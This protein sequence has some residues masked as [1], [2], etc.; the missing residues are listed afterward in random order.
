V[1]IEGRHANLGSTHN[2]LSAQLKEWKITPRTE[3]AGSEA[4]Q[5]HINPMPQ[6]AVKGS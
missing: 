3:S 4:K 5:V 6:R 1:P 2:P